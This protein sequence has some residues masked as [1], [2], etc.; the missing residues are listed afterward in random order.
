[1]LTGGIVL[2]EVFKLGEA[3]GDDEEGIDISDVIGSICKNSWKRSIFQNREGIMTAEDL[4]QRMRNGLKE[5]T[6][7]FK[8][9]IIETFP[10]I[11]RKDKK[12]L[13]EEALKGIMKCSQIYISEKNKLKAIELGCLTCTVSRRCPKCNE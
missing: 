6:K 11:K 5:E 3:G 9:M 7:N 12:D 13:K 8:H 1:M 2:K 4:A 10:T